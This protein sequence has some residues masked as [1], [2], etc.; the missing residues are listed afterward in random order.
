MRGGPLARINSGA[1]VLGGRGDIFHGGV[2]GMDRYAGRGVRIMLWR[3]V[4]AR[5]TSGESERGRRGGEGC[6]E[7]TERIIREREK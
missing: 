5:R 2:E 1:D 3:H 6:G 4:E 7:R